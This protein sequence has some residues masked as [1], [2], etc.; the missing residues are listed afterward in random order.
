[1]QQLSSDSPVCW[2]KAGDNKEVEKAGTVHSAPKEGE[3]HTRFWL[4]PA[5]KTEVKI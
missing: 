5:K 2:G 4:R 3:T 1:M